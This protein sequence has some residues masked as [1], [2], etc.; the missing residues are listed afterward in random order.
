MS[1]EKKKK[2]IGKIGIIYDTG[3]MTVYTSIEKAINCS[4]GKRI[5]VIVGFNG[6]KALIAEYSELK[7]F[8]LKKIKVK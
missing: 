7:N 6:E 3:R 2:L 5:V 1:D 8:P 4:G